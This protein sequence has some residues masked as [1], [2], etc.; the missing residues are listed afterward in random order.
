MARHAASGISG[1]S[2]AAS[3]GTAI[4]ESR[5][6]MARSSTVP[7]SATIATFFSPPF[8]RAIARRSMLS[9]GGGENA[10]IN[11]I[12]ICSGALRPLRSIGHIGGGGPKPGRSMSAVQRRPIYRLLLRCW[13]PTTVPGHLTG[14]PRAYLCGLLGEGLS[15]CPPVSLRQPSPDPS[16]PRLCHPRPRLSPICRH[17][18]QRTTHRLLRGTPRLRDGLGL[19][20][21]RVYT[22]N[23]TSVKPG[24]TTSGL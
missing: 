21:V 17:Q 10:A 12:I 19:I 16:P 14:A 7:A 5:V 2:V 20:S 22:R 18:Q 23:W 11:P 3:W 6:S 15:L 13:T 9:C 8:W 24:Q 1:T 4:R